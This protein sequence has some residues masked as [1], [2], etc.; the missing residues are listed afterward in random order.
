MLCW[1]CQLH[2]VWPKTAINFS[3][4]QEDLE[5]IARYYASAF[6]R[7]CDVFDSGAT[8]WLCEYLS[9]NRFE[10]LYHEKLW[11][12]F[13]TQLVE[14][15]ASIAVLAFWDYL[16]EHKQQGFPRKLTRRAEQQR[17]QACFE[18]RLNLAAPKPTKS[19]S[20]PLLHKQPTVT[21]KKTKQGHFNTYILGA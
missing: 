16:C 19:I 20:K 3:L 7:P 13:S 21:N 10:R 2:E 17:V 5:L 4:T 9:E 1:Q 12:G 11:K 8:K 18:K 14:S 6:R 15:E